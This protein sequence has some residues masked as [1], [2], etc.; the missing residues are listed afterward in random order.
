MSFLCTIESIVVVVIFSDYVK[1]AVNFP[2]VDT[3][4][5]CIPFSPAKPHEI[6]IHMFTKCI[7]YDAICFKIIQRFLKASRE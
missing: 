7:P 4:P 1:V 3:Y 2:V 6:F 5:V